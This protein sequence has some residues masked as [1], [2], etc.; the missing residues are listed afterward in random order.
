MSAVSSHHL[1]QVLSLQGTAGTNGVR[2]LCNAVVWEGILASHSKSHCS[3]ECSVVA[4]VQAGLQESLQM[5]S[6]MSGFL[7][8]VTSLDICGGIS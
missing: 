7:G 4:P 6:C 2:T 5:L 3:C 1:H 8:N